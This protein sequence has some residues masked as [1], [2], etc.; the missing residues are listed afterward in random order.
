[1]K[2]KQCQLNTPIKLTTCKCLT[3]EIQ[4][5]DVGR[6]SKM[7]NLKKVEMLSVVILNIENV[8]QEICVCM[9]L[10]LMAWL[11]CL[12]DVKSMS[13]RSLGLPNGEKGLSL[14][15]A[16]FHTQ[17]QNASGHFN[18][19]TPSKE[20]LSLF[21]CP[22]RLRL[23]TFRMDYVVCFGL[24]ASIRINHPQGKTYFCSFCVFWHLSNISELLG[25][26]V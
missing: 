10:T 17:Y 16:Y 20:H 19:P 6:T 3:M 14:P 22:H 15:Q 8:S 24:A 13:L 18:Q 21:L 23:C 5:R 26:G 7:K 11:P 4:C 9:R 2:S 1:M 25:D 12:I